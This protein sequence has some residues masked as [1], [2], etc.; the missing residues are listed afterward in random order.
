V[1]RHG[2]VFLEQRVFLYDTYVKD[3]STRKCWGKSRDERV[4]SRQTFH[5]L[6]NKHRTTGLLIHGK[7]K[8]MRRVL[9]E[10]KID[11]TGA[12]LEHTPRKSLK[13]QA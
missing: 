10:D 4:P 2:A 12:R 3:G 8:Y 6:V 5:N 1:L 13:R 11:D 7:R 9:T